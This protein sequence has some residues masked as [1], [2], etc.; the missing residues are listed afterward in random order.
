[1]RESRSSRRGGSRRKQRKRRKNSATIRSSVQNESHTI[2]P[3]QERD[4]TFSLL[5]F[6]RGGPMK[7]E[8]YEFEPDIN[9]IASARYWVGKLGGYEKKFFEALAPKLPSFVRCW[10]RWHFV[11]TDKP[12][13]LREVY[14]MDFAFPDIRLNIEIDGKQHNRHQKD[15]RGADVRRDK[16]LGRKG[17]MVVRFKSGYVGRNPQQCASQ[18]EE[19]IARLYDSSCS[20]EH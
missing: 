17:W 18:A 9:R 12:E 11:A 13:Y 10:P 7:L 1:M 5:D 3:L 19:L 14:E 2:V 16:H 8:E 4:I 20:G 15:F 6:F